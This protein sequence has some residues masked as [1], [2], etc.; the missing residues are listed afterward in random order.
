MIFKKI[1][2]LFGNMAA[3]LSYQTK[4]RCQFFFFKV[5]SLTNSASPPH[6]PPSM[7]FLLW[8]FKKLFWST[9]HVKGPS[10]QILIC[11]NSSFCKQKLYFLKSLYRKLSQCNSCKWGHVIRNCSG[12]K[13]KKDK[14]YFAENKFSQWIKHLTC[15]IQWK[16]GLTKLQ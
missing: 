3:W 4:G 9:R 15:N 12:L 14:I 13:H 8:F 1:F 16:T 2:D 10:K 6:P 11:K 7:V 5:W